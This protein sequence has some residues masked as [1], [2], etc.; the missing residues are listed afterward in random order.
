MNLVCSDYIDQLPQLFSW[1]AAHAENALVPFCQ[2]M[3]TECDVVLWV[4][5]HQKHSSL[6]ATGSPMSS[7]LPKFNQSRTYIS[8]YM[9]TKW[10]ML[11]NG[12]FYI[13]SF[14]SFSDLDMVLVEL[15]KSMMMSTP[16]GHTLRVR[17]RI[18]SSWTENQHPWYDHVIRDAS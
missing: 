1:T 14:S 18:C 7:Y 10:T 12:I 4:A 17:S 3:K 8:W 13:T 11:Q 15:T 2:T 9:Y 5:A 16:C 6:L